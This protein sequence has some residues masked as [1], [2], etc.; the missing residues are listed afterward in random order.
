M[1]SRPR[2][3]WPTAIRSRRK[4]RTRSKIRKRASNS[5]RTRAKFFSRMTQAPV[6][7]RNRH[8][9]R[10]RRKP[11]QLPN[12]IVPR[13]KL[14]RPAVAKLPS[15]ARCFIKPIS[16]RRNLQTARVDAGAG[17]AR[18]AQHPRELRSEIDGIQHL[19]LHQ[20]CVSVDQPRVRRSRF[21]LRRHLHAAG[22]TD[23]RIDVEG[24]REGTCEA[25][26]R[27]A[28][29]SATRSRRSVSVSKRDES[30]SRN[31]EELAGDGEHPAT[32]RC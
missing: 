1:Y 16:P 29:R 6:G 12:T 31:A 18:V 32:R 8:A 19:A 14:Q 15:P 26:Q 3:K 17:D 24:V 23:S 7:R 4:P 27:G 13:Q 21:L 11:A 2:S 25:D 5:G 9:Y 10:R 30:V 20:Y 28:Q 22:R